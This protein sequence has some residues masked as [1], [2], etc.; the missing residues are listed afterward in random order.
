M[1]AGIGTKAQEYSETRQ[2]GGFTEVHASGPFE[3]YLEKG[4]KESVRIE[5]DGVELSEIETKVSG[6][7]LQI[8]PRKRNFSWRRFRNTEV[9]IYVTYREL[10]KLAVHGSG[11]IIGRSPI[12]SDELEVEIHGS[13][14]ITLETKADQLKLEIHGSGDIEVSGKSNDVSAQ[15]HGSGDI[16]GYELQTDV[17]RAAIHGSGE[18]E[19]TVKDEIDAKVY[20]SGNVQYKG[21]PARETVKTSGSGEVRR[22]D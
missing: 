3:V 9:K 13:G 12:N 18:I 6:G 21:N 8:E 15:I 5:S 17:L 7:R 19:M 1:L 2:I 4:R 14:D 20:G 16:Q 10:E 11:N 22:V